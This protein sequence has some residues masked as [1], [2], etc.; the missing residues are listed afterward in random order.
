MAD[1]KIFDSIRVAKPM[2]SMFDLSH[3]HKLS[4]K[5]GKLVPILTQET[6]PGD[7]FHMSS[8]A[9]FRLMPLVSPMMHPVDVFQH[10][11]FVP[12]R[13]LW[14]NFQQFMSPED[15]GVPLP[16][17]PVWPIIDKDL[18][19]TIDASTLPNYL[20]LP[21]TTLYGVT[22]DGPD[23]SAMPFAAYQRIFFEFYRDQNLDPGVKQML[24]DGE[25]TAP[26]TADLFI[27][28]D[29]AWEHDYFTSALPFAQK[30][31]AVLMPLEL[32]GDIG[33]KSHA[34]DG[35]AI[36]G[37]TPFVR[38]STGAI[39]AGSTLGT[40]GAGHFLAVGQNTAYYDPDADLYLDKDDFVSMTT[41]NDLRTA[42]ALQRWLELA[43]RG[44]TRYSETLRTFFNVRS[45]DGRLQR[46]EY[47]GG[48]VSNIA[49]SE[50][51]Q[52]SETATTAQGTMAGHGISVSG[53]RDFSYRC[54]EW[55]FIIGL[56]SIRPRTAY[57]QGIPKLFTKTIDRFQYP[58]PQ[59]V[60]L[61][62]EEILNKE[63]YYDDANPSDGE[64]TFGYIPRYSDYRFSGSRVT[65]EMAT[66]LEFWHMGRKFSN[67]PALNSQF[68]YMDP[69]TRVF[70]VD[71]PLID[72]VVAHVYFKIMAK[73][74]LPKYG[75]P[76]GL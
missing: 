57:Y 23:I 72:T 68:V 39:L 65:G 37:S 70:A 54:E 2:H 51:L 56:L 35:A 47:I 17:P 59:F 64:D 12:N 63:I 33:I 18:G 58:W 24:R 55:G 45:S 31:A 49:I 67:T 11:W 30:G 73:R 40:D 46:P 4:L 7:V 3:D 34:A 48:S 26:E 8:Q 76:G 41:I 25:Q 71:N 27:L 14:E 15:T 44:G 9:L 53:G 62:E 42:M 60:N 16:I 43:A 52:T 75:T 1:N 29:R 61:G 20:G 5:M 69:T 13:I 66:T 10:F 74:C 36:G 28:R 32:T 19:Y 38:D 21:V 6:I 50:V 22:G